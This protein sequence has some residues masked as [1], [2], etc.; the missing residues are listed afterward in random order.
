MACQASWSLLCVVFSVV[1]ASEYHSIV[2][3]VV[4]QYPGKVSGVFVF[5]VFRNGKGFVR[6][7]VVIICFINTQWYIA[8]STIILYLAAA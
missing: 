8:E 7:T 4:Y 1:F 6:V 2:E 5:L 3:H